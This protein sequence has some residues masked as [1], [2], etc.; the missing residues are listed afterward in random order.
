MTQRRLER[1]EEVEIDV[2]EIPP[3][4][5]LTRAL[6]S[7]VLPPVPAAPEDPFMAARLL[8][9]IWDSVSA[10][11]KKEMATRLTAKMFDRIAV[12]DTG[13]MLDD[14][15]SAKIRE[16]ARSVDFPNELEERV[17]VQ[18]RQVLSAKAEEVVQ[19]VTAAYAD[20]CRARVSQA[21]G[22]RLP[23]QRP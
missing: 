19:K 15:I 9:Q 18:L 5:Q 11:T 23:G 17:R 13:G 1:A 14:F 20:E 10:S 2:D 3:A 16:I 6:K 7:D 8:M 12:I 22:L 4:Q 21:L